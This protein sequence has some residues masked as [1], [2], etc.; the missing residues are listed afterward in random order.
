VR[1]LIRRQAG[2]ACLTL[3]CKASAALCSA[4]LNYSPATLGFHANQKSVRTFSF[5]N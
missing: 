5:S 3:N 4:S 1:F 2:N